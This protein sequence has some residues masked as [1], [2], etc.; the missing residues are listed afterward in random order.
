MEASEEFGVAYAS[1]DGLEA[2]HGGEERLVRALLDAVPRDLEPR[3]GVGDA[4]FPAF[5][6]A[7]TADPRCAAWVPA[8]AATFLGPLSIDLL[9]LSP[10][11]RAGMR[12]FGIRTMGDVASMGRDL[13]AAQFGSEGASA[14]E[15]SHGVDD[16]PLVPMGHEEPVVEHVSL[17]FASASLDVLAAAVDTLLRRAYSRPG[18]QG[19]EAGGALLECALHRAVPWEQAFHFKGGAGDWER[20]SF[21][22]RRRLEA[23]RLPAPVE[24]LTLTLTDLSGEQGTQMALLRDVRG[25]RERRLEEVE[26]QFKARTGGGHALYRAAVVAPWHP[27]PEMRALQAPIGASGRDGMRPFSVPVPVEVREGPDEAPAAVR[28]GGRWCRGDRGRGAV[29]LRP[30]VDAGAPI[31]HLLPGAPR[32]RRGGDAVPRPAQRPLVPAGALGP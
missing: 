19:R 32:G 13:L 26:R 23:D 11:A 17:P 2:L 12:R 27:A 31:P 30:V 4:K 5:A 21:I 3:V 6:A 29:E 18:M 28:L 24:E 22:V 25:D 10:D 20:V 1:L 16:S 15:L 14:W 8:D 7:M 9:P